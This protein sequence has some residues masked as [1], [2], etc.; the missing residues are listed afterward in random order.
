[1]T[2]KRATVAEAPD[3]LTHARRLQDVIAGLG[4]EAMGFTSQSKVEETIHQWLGRVDL[5]PDGPGSVDVA[6]Q[7]LMLALDLATFAPS[8][9]GGTAIDRLAR[10][11]KSTDGEEKAALEALQRA[12]FR[13]LRIRSSAR[14]GLVQLED[15]AT[16][17]ALSLLD[18]DIPATLEGLDVA[19]RLCPLPGGI[20]VTVG[21]LT[22]L[23]DTALEVAMA[24]VRSGKGLTN[25]QRC[26]AAVY[27]HVVRHGAP[28]IPGLN[29]FP[30]PE[31]ETSLFDGEASELDRLAH[32][33]AQGSG[34]IEPGPESVNAA[35]NLSSARCLL[36]ALVSSI[37]ARH[38]GKNRLADAYSRLASIQIET[39]QRR[40]TAGFRGDTAPLDLVASALDHAIAHNRLPGEVRALFDRLRR[41][42]LA[43]AGMGARSGDEDLARVIQRIQAMRAKTVDQGCTE[44][45]ALASATKVAELLD[46]YGLSL[47]EIELRNQVCEGFGVDTDRLRRNAFDEC[48]PSIA[49][50]CD[51]KVW[52][53]KTPTG[54][55]RYVFF[56]LPADVEAA[57]FLYDRIDATFD[58]ESARFKTG[59]LYAGA[60]S[61]ERRK[62]LS[63]FQVGLSHGI[64]GK[65]KTMKAARDT[66]NRA[67]S[68]RD[69]APLKTAAIDEELAKLGLS[70]HTARRGAKKHVLVDAYEAGQVAGRQF[71]V[72]AGI[73]AGSVA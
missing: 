40:A 28:Q 55:I 61:G 31:A 24:F 17:A 59:A 12:S 54:A 62:A 14:Q 73:D 69:L 42:V 66:S 70:F 34:D 44:Q 27:R 33:W 60:A 56:G 57:R 3:P 72:Q 63:S 46:R 52:C 36:D 9:S 16:G 20:F 38:A 5:E 19:A 18:R 67:S 68:G 51:C 58:T 71:E 25:P 30:E 43:T 22:P 15:L 4:I 64:G 48:I 23:D 8:F 21:P 32:A 2:T 10:Q 13:L 50:F 1:M 29:A 35:R 39:L 37:S 6:A 47:D 65:L 11:R 45:E 49:G 53:D 7:A 41:V 26:A